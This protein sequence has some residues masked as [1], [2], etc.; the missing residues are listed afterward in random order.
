MRMMQMWNNVML[1]AHFQ[2]LFE[3]FYIRVNQI[4]NSS[5]L[6]IYIVN[7]IDQ[8]IYLILMK[9]ITYVRK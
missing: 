8:I 2:L 1:E 4:R 6:A 7:W 5:Y 3:T 9:F